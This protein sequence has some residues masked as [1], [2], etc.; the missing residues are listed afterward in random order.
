MGTPDRRPAG[1]AEWGGARGAATL[2]ATCTATAAAHPN[3]GR[4]DTLGSRLYLATQELMSLRRSLTLS[5]L[6]GSSF[7]AA[8]V[9][10]TLTRMEFYGSHARDGSGGAVVGR[11]RVGGGAGVWVQQ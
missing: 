1:P 7:P 10:R 11:W 9:S 5:S 4:P 2:P 6:D 8:R 3:D